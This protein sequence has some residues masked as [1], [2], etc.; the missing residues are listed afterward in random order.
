MSARL[1][2]AGCAIHMHLI[3]ERRCVEGGLFVY[4]RQCPGVLLAE[5]GFV[6]VAVIVES[7]NPPYIEVAMEGLLGDLPTTDLW[8]RT[9][10]RLFAGGSHSG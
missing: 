7:F 10:R 1:E 5:P 2:Y 4:E 8:A 3:C 6:S 9:D